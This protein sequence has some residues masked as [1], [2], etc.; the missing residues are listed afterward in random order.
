MKFCDLKRATHFWDIM[1]FLAVIR[2]ASST[3]SSKELVVRRED[4]LTAFADLGVRDDLADL[5]VTS[6]EKYVVRWF[7]ESDNLNS[8]TNVR[9]S[10]YIKQQES[11]NLSPTKAALKFKVSRSHLICLIRKSSHL[12][13]PKYCDLTTLGSEISGDVLMPS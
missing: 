13:I 3:R 2:P 1:L 6:L 7:C 10:M 4:V 9:W 5:T 12:Q 8:L 11:D